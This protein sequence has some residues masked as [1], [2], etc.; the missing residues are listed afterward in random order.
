MPIFIACRRST[1]IKV[2]KTFWSSMR[3]GLRRGLDA[4]GMVCKYMEFPGAFHVFGAATM[5]LKAK[6]VFASLGE[7]FP[8]RSTSTC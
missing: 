7:I 2:R 1:F 8:R 3:G 5:T 4:L 6:A